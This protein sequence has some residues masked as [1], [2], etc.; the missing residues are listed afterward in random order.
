[1]KNYIKN[2]KDWRLNEQ[3]SPD[4]WDKK[5]DRK[6]RLKKET[7]NKP[8]DEYGTP[9]DHWTK[10]YDKD[11]N[12]KKERYQQK[13]SPEGV[14]KYHHSDKAI[15]QVEMDNINQFIEGFTDGT[16]TSEEA[17]QWLEHLGLTRETL[18]P[19][20]VY[21]AAKKKGINIVSQEGLIKKDRI[22]RGKR[23]T[24]QHLK[25]L[26]L[27]KRQ[28]RRIDKGKVERKYHYTGIK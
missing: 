10:K 5:F 1:M 24:D 3:E 27:T 16:W 23:F 7:F 28:K 19:E 4:D 15:K 13:D 17:A 18:T 12:L 9:M 2:F 20:N 8:E 22:G 26:V 21:N 6:G 11:G 14:M 25:D